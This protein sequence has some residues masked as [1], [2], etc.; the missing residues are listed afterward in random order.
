MSENGKRRRRDKAELL[1]KDIWTSVKVSKNVE[2]LRYE[3]KP[4]NN[5]H[6]TNA[7]RVLI[8]K[9]APVSVVSLPL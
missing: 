1:R 2:C 4:R 8:G 5:D 3:L 7:A 6:R 9:N